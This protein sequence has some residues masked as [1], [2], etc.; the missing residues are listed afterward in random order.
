MGTQE[1]NLKISDKKNIKVKTIDFTE[2]ADAG[3]FVQSGDTLIMTTV[4]VNKQSS[5]EQNKDFLPLIVEYEEK[6]YAGGKVKGV[7]YTRREG[8][9]SDQA[10][11]NARMV[12]RAIRPCF[13]KNF[14]QETQVVN[15]CLSWD[16]EN[17]PDIPALLGASLALM[18][19]NIPYKGPIGVVRVVFNQQQFIINPTYQEREGAEIDL[20]LTGVEDLETKEILINMIDGQAIEAKQEMIIQA[21]E[22]SKQYLKQSID[23]Q[24]NIIAKIEIKEKLEIQQED[25]QGFQELENEIKAFIGNQLVKAFFTKN[26]QQRVDKIEQVKQNILNYIKDKD[27]VQGNTEEEIES[28]VDIFLRKEKDFI[29]SQ[30]ILEQEKRV[31]GRSLDEVRE[32]ACDIDILPR[33]HGSGFFR[34]GETR[35]LSIL[36][37]GS[38]SDK[39]L[40][41][42]MEIIDQKHFIHH[43]N[44]PPYSVGEIK[45]MRGPKRRDIGHGM[46]VEKA[47]LPVIP[48]DEVFPYTIRIVSEILSSNGS[49]SMAS[50]SSSSLALMAAGVPIKTHVAG[51]ALGVIRDKQN[52]S[53]YKILTDIQGP[54]DHFGD[55][56]FKI[57]GTINGITAIQMDVKIDGVTI[58]I[59]EQSLVKA[60]KARQIILAQMN[61]IIS[62]PRNQVSTYAPKINCFKVNPSKVK[63][64]IGPGGTMINGIIEKYNVEIDVDHQGKVC[65]L[66]EDQNSLNQAVVVIKDLVAEAE[67]GKIYQGKVVKTLDFGAFVE[68]FPGQDG[69]IHISKLSQRRVNRVED[70]VKVGD[71]VK[72]LVEKIDEQGRISL[73]LKQI[74]N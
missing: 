7:R 71:R 12:D 62:F 68:I 15:T 22:Y 52:K 43:Y 1:F 16:Q 59:L 29:L 74:L 54:E 21:I 61:N 38:P 20:V 55:M 41:D 30:F 18:I 72:V 33:T 57:A 19:S 40:L 49:S 35:S 66:S 67:I 36:T 32:L 47:L 9:A 73:S 8:R 24:N 60:Q 64:I 63:H 50:I 25:V 44:F 3:I 34:R 39:Q 42:G 14:T 5:K 70:I 13:F 26:K 27:I 11:L 6:F 4:V 17:S 10:I 28:K 2:H 58:E 69:M 45:P 48:C 46:L 31:D 56:D 23:W 65:V 51:I 37:L 53:R